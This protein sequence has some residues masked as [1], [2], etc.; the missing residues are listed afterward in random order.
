MDPLPFSDQTFAAKI[1]NPEPF[2]IIRKTM[3]TLFGQ[4]LGFML[5]DSNSYNKNTRSPIATCDVGNPTMVDRRGPA[6]GCAMR[7]VS[8]VCGQYQETVPLAACFHILKYFWGY[9]YI[10]KLYKL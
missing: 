8:N 3:K 4:P 5:E 1:G 6:L 10:P 9:E 2:W 7:Q